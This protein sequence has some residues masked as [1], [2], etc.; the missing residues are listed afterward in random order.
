MRYDA[1]LVTLITMT[2]TA[3]KHSRNRLIRILERKGL[4]S[5]IWRHKHRV[6]YQV[7]HDYF[8]KRFPEFMQSES[9][10]RTGVDIV[11]DAQMEPIAKGFALSSCV[12]EV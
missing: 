9:A 7:I 2:F 12:A 11:M 10:R 8:R 6:V 1:C 5:A 4:P 3:I